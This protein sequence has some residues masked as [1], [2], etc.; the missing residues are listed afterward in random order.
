M[1]SIRLW[2]IGTVVVVI[3]VVALGWF[4]GIQPLL[5]Q[6]ATAQ[7]NADAVDA[8]NAQEQAKL[9]QLKEEYENI[10]EIRAEVE[11]AQ[12]SIPASAGLS[13]FILQVNSLA[14]ATGVVVSDIATGEGVLYV[15]PEGATILDETGEPIPAPA[16]PEN[17]VYV[18]LS[19]KISGPY[20]SVL[21]FVK[22]LQSG[23]RLFMVSDVALAAEAGAE[24]DPKSK[25]PVVATFGADITGQIYVLVDPNAGVVDEE[26]PAEGEPAPEASPS[27]SPAA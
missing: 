24:P 13:A 22:G 18:P 1:N 17:F 27:A 15:L 4:V 21:S 23:E 20:A 16:A 10:D 8:V 26:I 11:E 3:A 7:S 12:L 5:T 9:L 19:I 2:A 14:A 25:E 6:T